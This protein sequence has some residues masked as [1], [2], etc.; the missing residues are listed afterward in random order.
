MYHSPCGLQKACFEG[1]REGGA[2]LRQERGVKQHYQATIS[3]CYTHLFLVRVS[4]ESPR[5][6]ARSQPA[7]R[8]DFGTITGEKPTSRE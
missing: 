2:T 1:S 7:Y 8:N 3:D 6:T 5:D 4:Y